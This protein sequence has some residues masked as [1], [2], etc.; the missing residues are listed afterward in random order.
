MILLDTRK[1]GWY[2][3]NTKRGARIGNLVNTLS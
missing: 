2:A 1:E 3:R